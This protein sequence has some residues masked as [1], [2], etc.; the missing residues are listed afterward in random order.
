M[1]LISFALLTYPS[2]QWK[3]LFTNYKLIMYKQN[4]LKS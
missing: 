4:I 2:T 3:F 1:I